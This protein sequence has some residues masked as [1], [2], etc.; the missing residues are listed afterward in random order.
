MTQAIVIHEYGKSNVMSFENINIHPPGKD[1]LLIKQNAI[2][3]HYHD[4]YVRSG[5]Y[6]T[7]KLP[8]IPGLEAVGVIEDVG[9]GE[10]NFKSGDRIVYITSEY[11]A[12]ASKRILNKKLAI[13]LPDF[14]SDELIATNFSRGLTSQMLINFVTKLNSSQ[15]ILVSAASG[16]V[17]RL[18]CQMA[19][20]IGSKVIGSVSNVEK[21]QL[22]KKYGCD[23]VLLY[24]QKNFIDK[25]MDITNGKGVDIV[26]DSVGLDT[27]DLS[28][29]VLSICGHL[30][31]F[32]QSS[33]VVNPLKMETLAKKSLTISRPILFHYLNN[34][35]IFE[36]MTASVFKSF[37]D[38]F[39][40][41]PKSEPYALKDAHKAHDVLESRH[42]G[43]SLYLVP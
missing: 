27:F 24:D 30:I 13:K 25:I 6:K 26:F 5:L 16:G 39:L 28:I 9:P 22:A 10:L 32:G 40:N 37:E 8:G 43:G 1:E 29:E 3:V 31:N 35:N 34:H 15:T 23:H 21:A 11:G 12:Y 20:N 2:G 41:I 38:G 36:K 4:I 42:G 19:K 14:V 33:G 17:G 18:L 7:L